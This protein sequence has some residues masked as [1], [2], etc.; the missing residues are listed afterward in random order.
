MPNLLKRPQD[1][2]QLAKLMV[3]MA[4]GEVPHRHA[5]DTVLGGR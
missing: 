4:S 1:P 2:S 5:P 3:D